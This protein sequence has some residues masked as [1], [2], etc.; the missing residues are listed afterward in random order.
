[1]IHTMEVQHI[2]PQHRRNGDACGTGSETCFRKKVSRG[3]EP[4]IRA[5]F[6]LVDIDLYLP[7]AQ[8]LAQLKEVISCQEGACCYKIN[9]ILKQINAELKLSS[10]FN[11]IFKLMVTKILEMLD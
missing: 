1:M 11:S 7:N 4:L 9:T 6:S 2:V 3:C 10:V 5:E 8:M